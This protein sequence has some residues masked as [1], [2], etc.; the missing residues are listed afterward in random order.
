VAKIKVE[1]GDVFQISLGDE[2]HA[3]ARVLESPL[4]AFYDLLSPTAP[5][6]EE[7]VSSNIIFKVWVMKS[8][9]K[10]RFWKKIGHTPLIEELTNSPAFFKVDPISKKLSI[11]RNGVEVSATH[12]QC[13]GLERAA[14]WEPE[15]I[16]DRLRD[17]F[18]GVPNKWVES[19]KLPAT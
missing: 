1:A 9:F 19:L 18:R 7:I 8:S 3:F 15:H 14:V 12:Q 10:S 4:V 11:Y 17:H 2:G 5:S 13:E 6:V 16:E